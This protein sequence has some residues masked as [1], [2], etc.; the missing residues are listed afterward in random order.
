[1]GGLV[2]AAVAI[3]LML[4]FGAIADKNDK[5]SFSSAHS[6][7]YRRRPADL[8]VRACSQGVTATKEFSG[9]TPVP[10]NGNCVGGFRLGSKC[11]L[12]A[13]SEIAYPQFTRRC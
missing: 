11:F 7:S 9:H 13:A 2:T 8:C 4:F 6:L 12:S 3:G 10:L 5:G 1:M